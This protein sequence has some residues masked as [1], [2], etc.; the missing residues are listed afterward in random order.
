M[1]LTQ[2]MLYRCHRLLRKV[3]EKIVL[4]WSKWILME[5]LLLS[6]TKLYKTATVMM[7]LLLLNTL[8]LSHMRLAKI[9]HSLLTKRDC[10]GIISQLR[11]VVLVLL[12]ATLFRWMSMELRLMLLMGNSLIMRNLILIILTLRDLRWTV[13]P[14]NYQLLLVT[15]N[16]NLWMLRTIVEHWVEILAQ[17]IRFR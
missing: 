11:K 3:R 16:W 5:T 1:Y 12:A 17:I 6:L 4:A 7:R 9:K 10:Q 8:R 2:K 15:N 13:K 14:K